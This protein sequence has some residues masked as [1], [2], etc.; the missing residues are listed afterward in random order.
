ME[1]GGGQREDGKE[2]TLE[3]VQWELQRNAGG[4]ARSTGP[5]SPV[6]FWEKE[7][8]GGGG[9]RVHGPPKRVED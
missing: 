4:K 1:R 9:R 2:T 3:T 6:R 5:E 8:W 7:T